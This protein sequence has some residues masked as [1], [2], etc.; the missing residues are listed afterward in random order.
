[1]RS[2]AWIKR[3]AWRFLPV[4]VLAAGGLAFL[5]LVSSKPELAQRSVSEKV[6]PVRTVIGTL[7]TVQ[8]DLRFF[9]E[10]I[11]GRQVELRPLVGG[12]VVD[13]G[14]D[15]QDGGRVEAGDLLIAIDPFEYDATVAE[16]EADLA[17][18]RAR[19]RELQADRDAAKAM[20]EQDRT[21]ET[22]RQRDLDRYEELNRRGAASTRSFDDA[23]VALLSARERVIERRYAIERL[24]ANLARQQAVIQ[25]LEV[26][27]RRAARDLDDTRL[28]APFSGYLTDIGIEFGKRVSQ[29]DRVARLIDE[30]RLE[31][32]FN[33]GMRQFGE[34]LE[35]GDLKG[36][37]VQ[38]IW[39]LREQ[40]RRFNAV[41]A[42]TGSEIDTASG[43]ITVFARIEQGDRQDLLRPGAFVEIVMPGP[44]YD[45]VLRLP[46]AA[47]HDG[48]VMV[49]D[50]GGRLAEQPA[51]LVRHVGNDILVRGRFQGHE[52]VLVTP[53]P[54]AEAGMPVS[55]VDGG[56]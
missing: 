34:L 32:R 11:A 30:S 3:W 37:P 7:G 17:E 18:A 29:S 2:R 4:L 43:G 48:K 46:E 41:I 52:A 15:F 20:L 31:V 44:R 54:G 39:R 19:L 45:D 51:T 6:W 8:P 38:V 53:I 10:V 16:A 35:A 50:E 21:M 25:R 13:V 33:V 1:M 22:L 24:D 47:W 36:R 9:G 55:V 14:A 42:R 23:R 28:T 49:V 5:I 26:K 27:A 40:T 12:R 56:G